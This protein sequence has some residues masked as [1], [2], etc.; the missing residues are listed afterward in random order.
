MHFKKPFKLPLEN[1]GYGKVFTKDYH[2][3]FDFPSKFLYPEAFF[4]NK[5]DQ[6]KVV[7]LINGKYKD[8]SDKSFTYDKEQGVI[9]CEGK[10]FII[11]RGWG[12]LTGGGG[13]SL[14]AEKASKIQDDFAEFIISRIKNLNP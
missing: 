10:E 9:L 11:I 8:S 13:L 6:Q 2:M 14:E 1:S 4:I 5:D 12:Y 3:A 7:D